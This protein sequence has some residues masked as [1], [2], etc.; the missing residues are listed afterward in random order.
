MRL[1]HQGPCSYFPLPV[2][3]QSHR[4]DNL[5]IRPLIV[6]IFLSAFAEQLK[7]I[8][9][10]FPN[11]VFKS[12]YCPSR[13]QQNNCILLAGCFLWVWIW[14]WG[15]WLFILT[16]I[17]YILDLEHSV[18]LRMSFSSSS[19]CLLNDRTKDMCQH[20]QFIE[21][22]GSNSELQACLVNTLQ[23]KPHIQFPVSSPL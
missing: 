6:T 12:L 16:M 13:Q 17:S 14:A 23:T 11:V 18:Q 20:A 15:F 22:Q 21:W 4:G 1:S 3:L 8:N 10:W 5:E 2:Y 19:S 7:I 9:F